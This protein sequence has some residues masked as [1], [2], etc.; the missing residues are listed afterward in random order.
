MMLVDQE[1]WVAIHTRSGVLAHQFSPSQYGKLSWSREQR[2]VTKCTMH[3]PLGPNVD[4]LPDLVPWV[5]QL[6]VFNS[7]QELYWTGPLQK[8]TGTRRDLTLTAADP[9]ALMART[10]NPLTKR[11]DATDPA[12]PAGELW[13]GLITHHGLNIEPVIRFDPLGDRFD[14]RVVGDEQMVDQTIAQLVDVGLRWTVIA[15]TPLLGPV[16]V[17]P[18]AALSEDDFINADIELSRDGTDSYND[19]LVKGA[20]NIARARLPMHGENLQQIIQIGS[21]FG[22]GNVQRATEAYVRYY[23]SIRETL[24]LPADAALHPD[25]PVTMDQLVPSARFTM[26]AFDIIRT[27]ELTSMSCDV[28]NAGAFV[29][30]AME[31]IPLVPLEVSELTE[32]A[33]KQGNTTPTNQ[34]VQ[35]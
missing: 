6:S 3:A 33:S 17:D 21:M 31:S 12:V 13:N 23:G 18:I 34:G 14:F 35:L 15:G 7:R 9:S 16:G 4:R 22:V 5:H 27:W 29:S 11:W 32:A 2:Q 26:E 19:I 30:V 10:R 24:T 28:D 20:D 25:A 8:V 1:Q